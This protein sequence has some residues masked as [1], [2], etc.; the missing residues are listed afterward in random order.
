MEVATRN[1]N[2][3]IRHMAPSGPFSLP[4][5]GTFIRP[6]GFGYRYCIEVVSASEADSLVT[7]TGIRWG[8]DHDDQPLDDGHK[9]RAS[10]SRLRRISH[11]TWQHESDLTQGWA[12]RMTPRFWQ[13]IE[14]RQLELF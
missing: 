13:R 12:R 11:D 4:L 7:V 6:V 3:F 1:S 2:F 10:V 14:G 8:L 5:P 9:S